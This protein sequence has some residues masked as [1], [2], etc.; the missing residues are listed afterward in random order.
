MSAADDLETKIGNLSKDENCCQSH[1]PALN[2]SYGILD[3]LD[4]KASGLMTVNA[5]LGAIL[6]FS[7]N[8]RITVPPV[9]R[10]LDPVVFKIAA[11]LLITALLGS[12]T[13]CFLVVR[14]QW[15]FLANVKANREE[16][17][18][19]AELKEL[20]KVIVGR[21]DRYRWAWW[22][23]FGCLLALFGLASI[24]IWA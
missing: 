20:A 21:T 10:G 2:R 11:E 22:I 23:T 5:F 7:I 18:C 14:V 8:R 1:I 4:R 17:Y 19:K 15:P 3:V 16:G 9:I 12:A 6:A 24:Y 13:L